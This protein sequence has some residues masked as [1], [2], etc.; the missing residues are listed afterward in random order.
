MIYYDF[1]ILL[2]CP[3]SPNIEL[4]FGFVKTKMVLLLVKKKIGE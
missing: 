2:W 1:F 3:E 4:M